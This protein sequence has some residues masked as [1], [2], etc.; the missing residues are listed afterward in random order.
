MSNKYKNE[1]VLIKPII[2]VYFS[3]AYQWVIVAR[4]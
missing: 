3:C 1:Y 4:F 2:N